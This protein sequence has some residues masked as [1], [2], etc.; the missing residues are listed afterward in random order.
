MEKD[1]RFERFTKE[2]KQALIVAQDVAKKTATNY[3]GT[4]HILLG[5]LSQPNSLGASILMNFGVSIDNVN[6]VL[7]SVGRT[8]GTAKGTSQGGGLSG[9]AKKVIE[10]AIKCAQDHSHMFVG[11]EHLLHA[12]V[13]QDNTAATVIL[14]NMKVRPKDIQTEI[15]A[16]FETLKRGAKP[17]QMPMGPGGAMPGAM[18]QGNPLEFL[19]S[20]LQG[21]I[22]G[23]D[24]ESY[25]KTSTKPGQKGSK[26]PALDYF[27]EDLVAKCRA[28]KMDPIIGRAKEIERVI[29]ILQRKTKNNPVIIG[30]P[31]V[32]KT[33]V[34]EGL[35]HAIVKENVPDTMVDKRVLCLS[36][37]SVVAG[38]KYR[39]EFEERLKQI[40]DEASSQE[41]VILFIDELHTVVGAGSA[42][43][44]LD[45]ANI[46]KPALSRGN[47]R[48]IGAT[49]T[50]EFRKQIE[51]DAALERRFQPVVVEEPSEEETLQILKGLRTSFE[52]HHNLVITDE[53][54]E[55]S[56]R[57][58]KRYVNDRFLP[59]KAIDLMDEAAS[60][61]GMQAKNLKQDLVKHQKELNAIIQQKEE[62]VSKQDYEK[63]AEL[64]TEELTLMEK[65]E[66]ARKIKVPKELRGKIDAEDIAAVLS[67]ATGVPVT[68]LLKDDIARLKNLETL[69]SQ[70]IVGQKE[71]IEA[72]AK[73]I[74]RSRVGVSRPS[75]PIASFIFM[76]PTGVGKTELV[77]TIAKEIYNDED[78][79]IKID[80]SEFMERHNVS[81]LVGTTAGYVGYEEGGQLTKMIRSKPYSVVLL[82]EIEKA[83]PEVMNILLQILEDG[84]LTDGKGKKVDF[85]NTILIMTSNIGARQLTE[86]AGPIGFS[87]EAD[88]LKRA[89]G[90]F[91]NKKEDIMRELKDQFRPEFLN[92]VDKI[93]V[94]EALTHDNIKAIVKLLVA[95]LEKRLE[96]K[97]LKLQLSAGALDY[98][99]KLG[100]DPDYGARPARRVI[101]DH[102]EDVLAEALLEGTFKEGDTIKIVKKGEELVLKK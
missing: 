73:A 52:D 94:F 81:R 84:V 39:G 58:S 42:E 60:L 16:A 83:H 25:M 70:H 12:L 95:D 14:E 11:T 98:L 44:S 43:G 72:V 62:A 5:I 2:A 93:V 68:K 76:G 100:Y 78:A 92:R 23:G 79:L 3:V 102:V 13:R 55:A 64:R 40:I 61:K 85:R 54:L 51:N 22:Q 18:G 19:L 35:A 71:A 89:E 67:K 63:A 53:A 56:V 90:A 17:G 24:K 87:L 15:E 21:V 33:A 86:S 59:D 7:K 29:S 74:R 26:T 45:A 57:L 97:K 32:G 31:G 101:Q 77:K 75:R 30:E 20:G 91:K 41:N 82:D 28:G 38:T 27:T 99:A 80:M 8:A 50:N 34:V 65:V 88:E 36:M 48:V 69:L 9:F 4:E 46:L 96:I 10:D 66:E 6:L 1:N 49:T 37:A 47:L